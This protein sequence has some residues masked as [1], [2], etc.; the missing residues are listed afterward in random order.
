MQKIVLRLV[1]CP[2][3]TM[4]DVPQQTVAVEVVV[5]SGPREL[6]FCIEV[7]TTYDAMAVGNISLGQAVFRTLQ[8]TTQINRFCKQFS[9]DHKINVNCVEITQD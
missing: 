9:L 7:V 1:G 3:Q 2:T 6:H 4:L 5:A 8:N